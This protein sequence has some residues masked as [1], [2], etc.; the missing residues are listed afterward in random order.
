MPR[1][2]KARN[3]AAQRKKN[4]ATALRVRVKPTGRIRR[5][6]PAQV[7][8]REAVTNMGNPAR[9]TGKFRVVGYQPPQAAKE[10]QL[11][12]KW[13]DK[14]RVARDSNGNKRYDI[15]MKTNIWGKLAPKYKPVREKYRV[16][17]EYEVSPARPTIPTKVHL[18]RINQEQRTNS[19]KRGS[20]QNKKA[21][22]RI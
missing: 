15:Q 1:I 3:L 6:T 17:R 16:P 7:M 13:V 18:E 19:K 21:K 9:D 20:S 14:K 5:Q 8:K 2:F 12:I 10:K 11:G 22:R 4:A